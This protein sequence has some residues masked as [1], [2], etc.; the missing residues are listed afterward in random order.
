MK[1]SFCF[2]FF[3]LFVFAS[4]GEVDE[5]DVVVLT[6]SNFEKIVS[7]QDLLLIEFY[8]PCFLFFI[9]RVSSL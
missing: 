8:A 6:S 5:K 1:L 7:G 4:T 9:F 2:C 3:A